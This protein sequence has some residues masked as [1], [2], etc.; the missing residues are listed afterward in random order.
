MSPALTSPNIRATTLG[1]ATIVAM[2]DGVNHTP[3][4]QMTLVDRRLKRFTERITKR[5]QPPLLEPPRDDTA[6]GEWAPP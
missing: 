3:S 5:R 4:T 1:D 6:I 2:M